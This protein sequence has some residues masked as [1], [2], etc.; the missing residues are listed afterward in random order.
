MRQLFRE[1]EERQQTET[2]KIISGVIE[3]HIQPL[4]VQIIKEREGRMQS[5]LKVQQQLAELRNEVRTSIG[6]NPHRPHKAASDEVVIEGWL[7]KSKDG[8]VKL[9]EKIM[10]RKLGLPIILFENLVQPKLNLAL[11]ML[12]K[13]WTFL[14]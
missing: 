13:F 8:A 1:F 10:E 4:N 7:Q 5:I 2:K 3:Q 12:Q 9:V 11:L 6:K 14:N